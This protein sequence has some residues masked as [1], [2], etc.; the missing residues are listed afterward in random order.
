MEVAETYLKGQFISD[1]IAAL[2]W[3]II[4][5]S[6]VFLRYLKLRKFNVY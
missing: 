6:V 3:S 1:L 4:N 5:P 2:P